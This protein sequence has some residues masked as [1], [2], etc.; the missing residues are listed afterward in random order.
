MPIIRPITELRNR[1]NEISKVCKQENQPVF[2]TKNGHGELVVMSQGHYEQLQAR[3]DL[4]DKL[5]AAEAEE[6]AGSRLIPSPT[7]F[8]R[9]RRRIREKAR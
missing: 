4:Y 9:L 3:L 2:I 8:A 7:V 1:A 5:A 6:A